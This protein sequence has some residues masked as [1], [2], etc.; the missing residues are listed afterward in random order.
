MYQ[1]A[2]FHSI[3]PIF[4]ATEASVASN[5][6]ENNP[7]KPFESVTSLILEVSPK[8][9][10]NP[11]KTQPFFDTIEQTINLDVPIVDKEVLDF[12][13]SEGD[14]EDVYVAGYVLFFPN[15]SGFFE[16]PGFYMDNLHVRECYR[17]K[18]LGKMM[19]SAVASEAAKRGF[20]MFDWN[21]TSWNTKTIGFYV[22]LGAQEIKDFRVYRLSGQAL[23]SYNTTD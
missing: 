20:S 19:F 16:K 18:G 9:F 17:G 1:L 2:D 21:V 11:K 13:T 15:Y 12:Q 14:N 8:P 6:F 5:L 23:K 22:K 7:H 10:L 4:T 3:L